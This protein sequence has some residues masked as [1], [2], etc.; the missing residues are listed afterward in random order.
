MIERKYHRIS[1]NAKVLITDT[2][3]KET[4]CHCVEFSD[5]GIDLEPL[6][7]NLV[8]MNDLFHAGQVVTVQVQ[9]IEAAPIIK[10]AI[11]RTSTNFLGLRFLPTH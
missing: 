5:D 11:I 6:Q 2:Q 9:G 8:H 7:R 4:M 10:A 1:L 3:G